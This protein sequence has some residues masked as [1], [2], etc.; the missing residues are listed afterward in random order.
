MAAFGGFCPLPIRLGGDSATGWTAQQHARVAA[1]LV[2][3]VNSVPFARVTLTIA[4]GV[5][6]LH[7][8]SGVNGIGAAFAPTITSSGTGVVTLTWPVTIKDEY[9]TIEPVELRH[10]RATVHSATMAAATAVVQNINTVIV[11]LFNAAGAAVDGKVSIKVVG[12]NRARRI[13]H[14]DGATDKKNATRETTPYAWLWYNEYTS[15]M[16]SAFTDARTG[17]VHSMKL[18]L[19]RMECAVQ[20]GAERMNTNSHPDTCDDLLGEWVSI[21]KVR[22]RG[23]E[24]RHE[25]RQRCAAK[26][27]AVLG[28]DR[29]KVDDVVSALLGRFFLSNVRTTGASLSVPPPLT[30]WPGINPGTTAYNLG[31]GAWYSERSH[32][33]VSVAGPTDINDAGFAELMNVEL[34]NELDR[35]LPAWMTFNWAVNASTTGFLL[36]VSKLDFTGM[37]W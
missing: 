11:R 27:K 1:D 24:T 26:Y 3:A 12:W 32:L 35:D 19:S 30:S 8:Y 14:Y 7:R 5:V 22:I 18:A 31:G 16:G 9:K 17:L 6:T 36:D 29:T 13:G 21:L 20:R 23:D 2:S 10:A 4:A 33:T 34:Y 28:N 15:A 37:T 25:I